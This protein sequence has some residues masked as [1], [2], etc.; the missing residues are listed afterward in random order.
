MKRKIKIAIYCIFGL[1]IL[2]SISSFGDETDT[3]EYINEDF[4]QKINNTPPILRDNFFQT[5]LNKI[6]QCRGIIKDI[7][8]KSRYK[9]NYRII[10]TDIDAEKYNFKI[11]YYLYTENEDTIAMLVNDTVFEFSGQYMSFTP[12][13][14][15]RNSYILDVILEKRCYH[16]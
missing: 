11:T 1:F 12:V 3:I 14:T 5:K 13:S 6:F 2:F 10:L 4:F 8:K 15:K 7:D 9:R 16:C